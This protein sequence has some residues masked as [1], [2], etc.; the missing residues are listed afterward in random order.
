[1]TMKLFGYK[2]SQIRKTL[3]VALGALVLIL[4]QALT[5]A[6]SVIPDTVAV[7][8]TVVVG[9]ATTAGAFLVKNATLID[10]LDNGVG[11]D[12]PGA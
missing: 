9:A 6:A 4:T 8:I 2:P 1:M 5:S 3:I 7:W 11:R 12:E 10:G